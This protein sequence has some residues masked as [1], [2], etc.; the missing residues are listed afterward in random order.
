MTRCEGVICNPNTGFCEG[1]APWFCNPAKI[2]SG[3][4]EPLFC[5]DHDHCRDASQCCDGEH[6]SN[7]DN[8]C[9][10]ACYLK[11]RH[12]LQVGRLTFSHL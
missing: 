1:P 7:T 11:S 10:D 8:S 9:R 6:C 3:K 2:L 4:P 5:R 12:K